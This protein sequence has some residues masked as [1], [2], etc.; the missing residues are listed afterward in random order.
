MAEKRISYLDRT[1][2]DY[3]RDIL[4]LTKNYYS[5]IFDQM[6]DASVGSW[7]VDIISD[8]AD[9]L[10]YNIDKSYQE[11]SLDSANEFKSV[12]NIARSVGCKIT[13]RKAAL[14]EV[15][16][17]CELPLNHQGE[18]SYGDLTQADESY[19]PLIKRGTL[20][21][22]GIQ[23]FEL[24]SNVDFSK[25][26]DENGVS[27][28]QI[29]PTRDANGT[30]VSYTYSKLAIAAAGR[31]K[32]YRK[33]ITNSD[34][35]PFMEVTLTDP[36]IL[37]V[38][39]IILKDGLDLTNDPAYADFFV[40]EEEYTGYDGNRIQRFFE[41][42]NLLE[43]YRFGDVVQKDK[44]GIYNPIW[45]PADVSSYEAEV[46][47]DVRF[48][49]PRFVKYKEDSTVLY[50]IEIKQPNTIKVEGN[51][52][53]Y[54][55]D[56][57]QYLSNEDK[58]DSVNYL[59]G[60]TSE[61]SEDREF[62]GYTLVLMDT[63]N[64][65]ESMRAS[66]YKEILSGKAD[67]DK[68]TET[69]DGSVTTY[70]TRGVWKRFKNKF[71]TE[72]TDDWSL[73]VRFGKGI[74]NEY[75]EI[76]EDAT[77]FTKY[78]MCRMEANDCFGV[79]PEPGKTMFIL[80]RTGGGLSSNIARDT[81]TNITYINATVDGNCDDSEDA[82]KKRDVLNSLKVRNTTP[83]YGGKDQP[84][85]EEIKHLIKYHNAAQKRCVTLHDYEARIM[86][87]PP[88]YGC[89]F[90]CGVVEE[91]NKIVIYLL[92][93]DN[94]GHLKSTMAEQVAENIKNYLSHYK[95]INDLIE[96]RSGKIINLSFDIEIF[97]D[98]T[99]DKGDVVRRVIDLVYDYMDI[100]KHQMGGDI[101]VGDIEKEISKL[102]GVQ[103]LI[104]LKVANE[105]GE[106]YSN[107]MITQSLV[108]YDDCGNIVVDY[109]DMAENKYVDLKESDK[110]LYTESNSMFEIKYKNRD[111]K[112][113]VK[114]RQ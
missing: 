82:R 79:L 101:F 74:R 59:E 28:R 71:V 114:Q 98:K 25:Q 99:Y 111:I 76:P 31:S 94:E 46:S 64:I 60:L 97:V 67:Y 33:Q 66:V 84:S 50:P 73:K 52:D 16:L 35:V 38:E 57:W 12:L 105:T 48:F 2:D 17:T 19:A 15:E 24:M 78:L 27:N 61:T 41:V 69:I 68:R 91:N 23:T 14:V 36:E 30:I 9:T 107:S 49:V 20:F 103:N 109:D 44:D 106:A 39:S 104:S 34:V 51:D 7:L 26:F 8:V 1:Y 54:D 110:V 80:Y 42:D 40:D 3:R 18:D 62:K 13:G 4:Q 86:E 43:Q 93:L 37:E 53:E 55:D 90:R 32:I 96:I 95:M 63:Y 89:P 58:V 65:N 92:G 5:D 108:K 29:Y 88:K 72:F 102:D 87:I 6:N 83:S 112:V 100:N 85:T 81:L 45:V 47:T 113:T 70:V 56:T 22:T 75:G 10:S 77:A 11:T 21:S